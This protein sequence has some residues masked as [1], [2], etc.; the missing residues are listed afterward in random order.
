MKEG[1]DYRVITSPDKR[2]QHLESIVDEGFKLA[3]SSLLEYKE[4]RSDL[5][6]WE[7]K[8]LFLKF[9]T[10]YKYEI[11]NNGSLK[12]KWSLFIKDNKRKKYIKCPK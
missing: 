6:L 2:T 10:Y 12:T 7:S 1:V 4:Y 3:N 5:N 8:Y 11:W 9:F